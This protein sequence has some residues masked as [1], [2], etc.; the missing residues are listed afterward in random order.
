MVKRITLF[1]IIC[2]CL[3]AACAAFCQSEPALGEGLRG[4]PFGS[5]DRQRQERGAWRS[6]P[7]APLPD[8]PMPSAE[9]RLP[10]SL[11]PSQPLNQPLSP[12]AMRG[13]TRVFR[14]TQAAKVAPLLPPHADLFADLFY[15]ASDKASARAS[16]QQGSGFF[17]DKYLYPATLP[18]GSRYRASSSDGLIGRATDAASRIFWTRDGSGARRLNTSYFLRVATSIAADTASR[19]FWKRSA[20]GPF[21][22]FGSTI[23]NDA[24]MN[25]FHEFGP[26]LGQ[27]VTS[28]LP[29]FVSRIEER[30]LQN[31]SPHGQSPHNQN[32]QV[33]GAI[34]TR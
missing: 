8:A 31:Q 33:S 5:T 27:A 23:G 22:D 12:G 9:P 28:H 34:P 20:S 32:P 25:L 30:I 26:D 17:L 15:E 14:E 3:L 21:S 11:H 19:P 6:S 7:A 18:Q 16:A 2:F 24:G 29:K 4:L 1:R 10:F 13:N